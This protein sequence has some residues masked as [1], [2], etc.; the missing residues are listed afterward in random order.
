MGRGVWLLIG[1]QGRTDCHDVR[2][3]LQSVYPLRFAG[4]YAVRLVMLFWS[5]VYAPDSGGLVYFDR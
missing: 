5:P 1:D 4:T 2:S 3:S